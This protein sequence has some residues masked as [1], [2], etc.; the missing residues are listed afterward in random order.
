M[1]TANKFSALDITFIVIYSLFII[2]SLAQIGSTP[3]MSI[4]FILAGL[5]CIG[6]STPQW[7]EKEQERLEQKAKEMELAN[8]AKGAEKVRLSFPVGAKSKMKASALV[9]W[10]FLI[11]GG[12]VSSS[13]GEKASDSGISAP[14]VEAMNYSEPKKPVIAVKAS[15]LYRE[16]QQNEVRAN[17]KYAGK[18]LKVTAIVENI[19]SSFGDQVVLSLKAPE[20]FSFMSA[21]IDAESADK[22][23]EINKGQQVVLTCES[24]DE[25][26]GSPILSECRL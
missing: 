7:A 9:F 18:T 15:Q 10:G 3:I 20:M 21:N 19:D 24:V 16:Y 5:V 14:A 12:I 2:G 4:F 26:A 22:A 11:L 23:S 6:I 25:M 1:T 13:L 8:N 17:K